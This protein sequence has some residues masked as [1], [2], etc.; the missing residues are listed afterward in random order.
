MIDTAPSVSVA[1]FCG[2][3][4]GS[5]PAGTHIADAVGRECAA[6]GM[7]IVFGGSDV[8]LMGVLAGSAVEAG[9]RV[10]G[11]SPTVLVDSEPPAQGIEVEIVDSLGARKRRFTELSDAVLVLPGGIGSLEEAFEAMTAEHLGLTRARVVF[12]NVD[13]FWEP[14]KA[15]LDHLRHQGFVAADRRFD[16][17]EDLESA[18]DTIERGLTS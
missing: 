9:G 5:S 15:L 10:L 11:V 7:R 17:P 13:G 2:S 6:R 16:F 4:T 1:V 3:T 12:L 14:L 8:G 18:F